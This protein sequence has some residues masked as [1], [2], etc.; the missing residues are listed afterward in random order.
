[1]EV[2]GIQHLAHGVGQLGTDRAQQAAESPEFF[3][4][5]R[6]PLQLLE[7]IAIARRHFSRQP[8][9]LVQR[10]GLVAIMGGS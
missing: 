6:Q 3:E 7:P 5:A 2:E 1:M 4:L 10:R 9:G 8:V